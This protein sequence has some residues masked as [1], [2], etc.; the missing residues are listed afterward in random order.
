MNCL[1]AAGWILVIAS[2]SISFA[3]SRHAKSDPKS[4]VPRVLSSK[5]NP[6]PQGHVRPGE[7][8]LQTPVVSFEI[9]ADGKV[10]NARI[11][12]SSGVQDIDRHAL[13]WVR[14]LKYGRRPSTCPVADMQAGVTI[15]FA[16]D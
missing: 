3:Q 11:T 15:D 13:M 7:K 16:A 9:S 8:Y 12:R 5:D 14:S 10:L 4:C 1:V 6:P 2:T